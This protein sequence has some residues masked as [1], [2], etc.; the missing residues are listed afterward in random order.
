MQRINQLGFT[1]F[2]LA[3]AI[4][5]I[6]L[7]VSF[8]VMIGQKVTINTKVNRL[9]R[10]LNSIR[11]AIYDAQDKP[12]PTTRGNMLKSPSRITDSVGPGDNSNLNAIIG[13]DWR[14][15]SG[16]NF[17]LWKRIRPAGMGLNAINYAYAPLKMS[18]GSIGASEASNPPIAGINGDYVI[19]TNNIAGTLAKRLDFVMDDGNTS[20]GTMMASNQIGGAGIATDDIS[21]SAAYLICLG[22]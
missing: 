20:S 21:S 11:S 3:T 5:I 15:T 14:S 18:G 1:L 7:L 6:C 9:N 12:S 19:C 13:G 16:E 8:M 2:E 22:V 17:S 10:D 4:A